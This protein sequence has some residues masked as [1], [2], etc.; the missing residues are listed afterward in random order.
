MWI[1]ARFAVIKESRRLLTGYTTSSQVTVIM[2]GVASNL[3][4]YRSQS[5]LPANWEALFHNIMLLVVPRLLL[6]EITTT[7]ADKQFYF[8]VNSQEA[9][10]SN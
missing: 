4:F 5:R 8:Y 10:K 1:A 2:K 3:A 9:Q 7:F 6:Y